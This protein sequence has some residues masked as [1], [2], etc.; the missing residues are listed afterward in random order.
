MS[1]VDT[2]GPFCSI[3]NHSFRSLSDY[4]YGGVVY[5]GILLTPEEVNCYENARDDFLQWDS[6]VS[7]TKNRNL[8]MLYGNTLFTI[9]MDMYASGL[10]ISSFSNFPAEEE[11]LIRPGRAFSINDMEFNTADNKYHINISISL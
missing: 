1:K 10:D 9:E 11:V 5:R 4:A 3:L 2:L 8:A 6:F 7:T